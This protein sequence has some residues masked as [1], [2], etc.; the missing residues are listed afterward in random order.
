LVAAPSFLR[1]ENQYL[2][3]ISCFGCYRKR[4]APKNFSSAKI[5][6]P[7]A[8]T[9]MGSDG[10]M[11]LTLAFLFMLSTS[12]RSIAPP[13]IIANS[14]LEVNFGYRE[15]SLSARALWAPARMSSFLDRIN[16]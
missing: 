16:Q 9:I 4:A 8:G 3:D 15:R 12:P 13:P 11:I 5:A 7:T 14:P 10:I 1:L 6:A 2:I